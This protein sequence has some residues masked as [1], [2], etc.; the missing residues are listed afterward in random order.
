MLKNKV[1]TKIF[2]ACTLPASQETFLN[3]QN[4]FL[5][6]LYKLVKPLHPCN[7][8]HIVLSCA[9]IKINQIILLMNCKKLHCAYNITT[10][11]E[12]RY[13]NIIIIVK[14][15]SLQYSVITPMTKAYAKKLLSNCWGSLSV[16]INYCHLCLKQVKL[17]SQS[18]KEITSSEWV[19]IGDL[20]SLR[21]TTS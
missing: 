18:Q 2:F 21:F 3:I 20:V 17:A 6:S 14:L 1:K 4:A 16:W 7:I 15:I 11:N 5:P 8:W 19:Q 13:N 9:T 12:T 10:F